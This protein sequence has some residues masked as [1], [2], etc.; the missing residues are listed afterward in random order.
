MGWLAGGPPVQVL[1]GTYIG[2]VV[3]TTPK[4]AEGSRID[5]ICR[6]GPPSELTY[7]SSHEGYD[8]GITSLASAHEWSQTQSAG[9]LTG[10]NAALS[11]TIKFLMT[12]VSEP[13]RCTGIMEYFQFYSDAEHAFMLDAADY[14]TA[15]N[16]RLA[17]PHEFSLIYVDIAKYE[18]IIDPTAELVTE[19]G[20]K[21]YGWIYEGLPRR[22]APGM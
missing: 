18:S 15:Y 16:T 10:T 5:F 11:D 21:G 20:T 22:K 12:Y 17:L 13:V 7:P 1:S 2:G 9:D 14:S 3:D 6:V 19:S 8:C 4:Y